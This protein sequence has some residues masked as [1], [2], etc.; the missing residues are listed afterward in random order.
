[1]AEHN[2]LGKSGEELAAK[3]L[4]EK[5]YRVLDRNYRFKGSEVDLFCE[6]DN[7]LVVVEVKTRQSSYLAGPEETVSIS[8]Q[9]S[10]IKVTNQY[11]MERE[12]DW[13]CRFDIVSV[14]L[15]S[16]ELKIDHLEDAFY[17][18]F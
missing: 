14:I 3:Y 7:Q 10:I 9:R 12:I 8:K 5:G 2:Q 15:N 1:M 16:K 17:P 13:E 18:T 11:I 4:K 6:F